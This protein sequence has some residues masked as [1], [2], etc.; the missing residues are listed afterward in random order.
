MPNIA[1]PNSGAT[2]PRLRKVSELI[3]DKL[4]SHVITHKCKEPYEC[5]PNHV[6]DEEVQAGASGVNMIKVL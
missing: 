1:D 2:L 4:L 5:D 3:P 6:V